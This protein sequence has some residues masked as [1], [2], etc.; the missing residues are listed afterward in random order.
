MFKAVLSTAVL[1]LDGIYSVRTLQGAE[2]E[3]TLAGG[4]AGVPHC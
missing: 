3:E 4:L 2:R 1:P